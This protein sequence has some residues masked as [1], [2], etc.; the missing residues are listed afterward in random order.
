MLYMYKKYTAAD[1][2]KFVYT[3]EF[4]TIYLF[5]MLYAMLYVF[6]VFARC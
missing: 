1:T 4:A 6:C 3:T 2:P 5:L